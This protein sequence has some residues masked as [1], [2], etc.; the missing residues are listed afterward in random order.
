MTPFPGAAAG[1]II[2]AVSRHDTQTRTRW[3]RGAAALLGLAGGAWG[4]L[5]ALGALDVMSRGALHPADGRGGQVAGIVALVLAGAAVAG[6]LASL[7]YPATGCALLFT[8]GIGGPLAVGA[9]WLGPAALLLTAAMLALWATH[10]PFAEQVR[11][12][13]ERDARLRTHEG[14]G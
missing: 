1:R 11:R 7:A 13:R 2:G 6:A 3:P 12:E 10:D 8:A 5:V 14:P 4:A 9:T